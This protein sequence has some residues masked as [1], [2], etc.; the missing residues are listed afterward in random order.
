MLE[1]CAD[2]GLG[3]H[4][5]LRAVRR[6]LQAISGSPV[7]ASP[8]VCFRARAHWHLAAADEGSGLRG[9][10]GSVRLGRLPGPVVATVASDD[11]NSRPVARAGKGWRGAARNVPRVAAVSRPSAPAPR[12][13]PAAAITLERPS[14]ANRRGLRTVASHQRRFGTTRH[15][16]PVTAADALRLTP[17][18]N[19]RANTKAG[20]KRRT[21]VH[22]LLA[23]LETRRVVS[24]PAV[25][26]D[27][28][29][30]RFG[31]NPG[32]APGAGG[33]AKSACRSPH[34]CRPASARRCRSRNRAGTRRMVGVIA[35]M[36][37][38]QRSHAA[39]PTTAAPRRTMRRR[40]STR[41][42]V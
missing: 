14:A 25:I 35:Q 33:V 2:Q 18:L 7:E 17:R 32:A 40:A 27:R 13:S 10:E 6:C 29:G 1:R 38:N 5:G 34:S 9:E 20:D 16:R 21:A 26:A 4:V 41:T 23:N 22:L 3:L 24:A 19:H 42:P 8:G 12:R 37:D 15:N 11:A 28:P 39:R 36:D 30:F 31:M